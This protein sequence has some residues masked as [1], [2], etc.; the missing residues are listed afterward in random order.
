MCSSS[1]CSDSN[2]SSHILQLAENGKTITNR[3]K[4]SEQTVTLDGAAQI[5][6][7]YLKIRW[8]CGRSR[9]GTAAGT[10]SCTDGSSAGRLCGSPSSRC[11]ASPAPGG[12]SN[13][14]WTCKRVSSF[15][16]KFAKETWAV[17]SAKQ[18]IT[19]NIHS[20]Q[21]LIFLWLQLCPK[22]CKHKWWWMI[23]LKYL[24]KKLKWAFI[25]ETSSNQVV[26]VTLQ[27]T[28]LWLKQ[29]VSYWSKALRIFNSSSSRKHLIQW[30]TVR[31]EGALMS[32]E[33]FALQ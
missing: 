4:V 14:S 15:Q 2:A 30:F 23:M 6:M 24:D 5:S 25:N 32:E 9:C 12:A 18:R 19:V 31:S 3:H 20:I 27:V 11:S 16:L 7:S 13:G 21:F 8:G 1:T 17:T 22:V 28:S 29:H 26:A 33:C 10:A